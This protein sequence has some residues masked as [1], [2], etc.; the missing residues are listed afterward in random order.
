MWY[1]FMPHHAGNDTETDNVHFLKMPLWKFVVSFA[2]FID[3][4]LFYKLE[5][6]FIILKLT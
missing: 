2:Q 5:N 6:S 1:I 3:E 4:E